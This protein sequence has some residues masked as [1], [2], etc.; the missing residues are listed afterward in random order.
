MD[1]NVKKYCHYLIENYATVQSGDGGRCAMS[2]QSF[3]EDGTI[4]DVL[5]KNSSKKSQ[6][7]I[8]EIYKDKIVDFAASKDTKLNLVSFEEFES[9]I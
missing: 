3:Y 4:K 1:T 8:L 6:I 2:L 9:T 5:F 7:E